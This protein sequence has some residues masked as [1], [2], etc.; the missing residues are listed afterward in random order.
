MPDVFERHRDVTGGLLDPNDHR[1]RPDQVLDV[2]L[3]EPDIRHPT[4]AVGARVVKAARGL[5]QHVE[6]HQKPEGVLAPLVVDDRL[7]DD[8]RAAVRERSVGLL[9]Q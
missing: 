9:E 1:V 7:I 6:A 3:S 5:D 4:P 2:G 8:Q